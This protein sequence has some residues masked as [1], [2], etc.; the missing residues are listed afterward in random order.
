LTLVIPGLFQILFQLYSRARFER[1][2]IGL[3]GCPL[4]SRLRTCRYSFSS[5]WLNC[6]CQ[7]ETKSIVFEQNAIKAFD[8][9]VVQVNQLSTN[10]D[11]AFSTVFSM[12][13]RAVLWPCIWQYCNISQFIQRSGI[14]GQSGNRYCLVRSR[15]AYREGN[16][17]CQGT[18][19]VGVSHF[20]R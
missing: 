9:F 19:T 11:Q 1:S 8:Y 2:Q 12:D 14:P 7:P 20:E 17:R 10:Y 18:G 13:V 3:S 4:S 6:L 16:C 5:T 15:A